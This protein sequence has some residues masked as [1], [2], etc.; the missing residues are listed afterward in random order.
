MSKGRWVRATLVGIL[1]GCG[2]LYSVGELHPRVDGGTP[3]FPLPVDGG[4]ADSGSKDSGA[5]CLACA[6][7]AGFDGGRADGGLSDGGRPD[8]GPLPA[9]GG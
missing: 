5:P 2:S 7:D 6:A 4:Y 8:G 3:P 1:A 9:D